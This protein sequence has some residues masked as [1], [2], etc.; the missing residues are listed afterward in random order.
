MS[1]LLY[2]AKASF[3]LVGSDDTR[4]FDDADGAG[5]SGMDTVG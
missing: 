3:E 5:R 2:W 4:T 1:R